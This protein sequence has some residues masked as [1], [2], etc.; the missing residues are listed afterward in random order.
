MFGRERLLC[1]V[2]WPPEDGFDIPASEIPSGRQYRSIGA[3]DEFL[4]S[5]KHFGKYIIHGHTPVRSAEVPT[6]RA[7]IYTGAY[8][9]ENLTLLS[10]QGS[11]LLA[12]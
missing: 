6:N 11:R 9:T 8:A 12:V 10:I 3:G 5:K 4:Q 1:F 7:N 2:L